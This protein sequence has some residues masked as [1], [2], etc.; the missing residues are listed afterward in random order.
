MM[1]IRRSAHSAHKLRPHRLAGLSVF[2]PLLAAAC[3]D[4]SEPVERTGPMQASLVQEGVP[5]SPIVELNIGGEPLRLWP[6]T[7]TNVTGQPAGDP[8]NLIFIGASDPRTVRAALM[9]LGGTRAGPFAGFNCTWSD[10]MGRNQTAYAEPGG[11]T[12]SAIQLECGAYET[13]RFHVRLFPAGDVTLANAHFEV[14]I[15]GTTDH[16]VLNWELAEQFVTYDMMRTGLV[17]GVAPA[18][19]LNP[20]PTYKT[21]R[22]EVY[23]GLPPQLQALVGAPGAPLGIVTNGFATVI[24]LGGTPAAPPRVER[25]VTFL[26]FNQMIPKPFCSTGPL[27]WIYVQGPIRLQQHVVSSAGGNV[28]SNFQA[29]GHLDVTPVNPIT[30]QAVGETY[31]ALV[32]E[33]HRGIVTDAV[34]RTSSFMMQIEIPPTGSDRGRLITRLDVGPDGARYVL[35]IECTP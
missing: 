35:D 22:P 30:R 11:W 16:E 32:T 2:L 26:E 4:P 8:I 18:G 7:G 1:S 31:R 15:P 3:A 17:L 27:H 10:A 24:A 19:P 23:A 28:I 12:G 13:V 9:S 34:T 21:V 20:S 14:M 6:F 29:L 5:P 33:Q 25:D